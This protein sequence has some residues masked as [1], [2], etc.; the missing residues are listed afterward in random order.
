MKTP[1]RRRFL[2][3]AACTA[4][5]PALSPFA[6]AQTYPTQPV[7]LIAPFPAGGVVDLFSRLIAQP[8]SAR[9]GQPVIV[10][11]RA[12]AGGNVGTEAV[13]RAAPDGYTLL[14]LSS[15]NALNQTLYEKLNFDFVRDIAPIASINRGIGVMEV[16]PSFPAKTVSE[17]IAYAKAHPGQINMAS[18]GIGSSQHIYGELFKMMAGI[19]MVHVPYRGGGPAL[20]D[21][22][23]GQVQIMFD[24]IAT[25]IEQIRAGKLRALAVTGSIR[26]AVLPDIPTIDEFVPGYEATGWQG[27]GAPRNTPAEII[28]SLHEKINAS[29]ADPKI[30]ARIVELG[31]VPFISSQDEFSSFIAESTEKWRKII[32]AANI[33]AE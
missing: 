7:H 28:N 18:G 19:D 3:L 5:L 27:I 30:T 16:H 25:S 11:N 8:L 10:E 24:T 33:K 22:I 1:S 15:S 6:R 4:A 23:A 31:Y 13:V 9:L 32:R 12:G 17:F 20:T 2:H 21:L 26:S 29:L 14:Y